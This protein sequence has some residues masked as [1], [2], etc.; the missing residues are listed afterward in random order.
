MLNKQQNRLNT[1]KWTYRQHT[2][3]HSSWLIGCIYFPRPSAIF[4]TPFRQLIT[5]THG[6]WWHFS[7]TLIY[8][9]ILFNKNQLNFAHVHF[10]AAENAENLLQLIEKRVERNWNWWHYCGFQ[11]KCAFF[12]S[13]WH[14]WWWKIRH[15]WENNLK[16]PVSFSLAA[17]LLLQGGF[18]FDEINHFMTWSLAVNNFWKVNNCSWY[19][20]FLF[21]APH[22]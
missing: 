19:I 7:A 22:E 20:D 12:G 18:L 15:K 21:I 10:V 11:V 1:K 2:H 3:T 4:V 9:H 5:C 13:E 6:C 14:H 16:D 17:L 8:A